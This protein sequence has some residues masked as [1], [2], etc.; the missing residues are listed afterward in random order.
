M[1]DNSVLDP[2]KG[3]GQADKVKNCVME[4]TDECKDMAKSKQVSVLP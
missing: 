2:F 1:A 4:S 3:L